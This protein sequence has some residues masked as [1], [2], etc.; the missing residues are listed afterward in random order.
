MKDKNI[1]R[2]LPF[3][4]IIVLETSISSRGCNTAFPANPLFRNARF[5]SKHFK[6]WVQYSLS[7]Y[8]ETLV[9]EAKFPKEVC[10]LKGYGSRIV[11]RRGKQVAKRAAFPTGVYK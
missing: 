4:Q 8:P 9:L 5:R 10:Y 7:C 1:C 2:F 6:P 3:F 11:L